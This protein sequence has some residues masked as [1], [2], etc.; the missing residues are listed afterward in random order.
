MMCVPCCVCMFCRSAAPSGKARP[1]FLRATIC[2]RTWCLRILGVRYSEAPVHIA[3]R[4]WVHISRVK[5]SRLAPPISAMTSAVTYIPGGSV[6]LASHHRHIASRRPVTGNRVPLAGHR[7]CGKGAAAVI[8]SSGRLSLA[9]DRPSGDGRWL[10][11]IT[12]RRQK[13]PV[14]PVSGT[15][16]RVRLIQP[17]CVQ[18]LRLWQ[19]EAAHGRIAPEALQRHLRRLPHCDGQGIV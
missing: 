3:F 5:Y 9:A 17:R 4:T 15:W 12:R 6:C 10:R 14:L 19:P 11:R 7:S 18:A 8:A 2:S 1:I 13:L 16:Q